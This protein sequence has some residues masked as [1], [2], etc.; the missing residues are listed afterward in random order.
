MHI[1]VDD[2]AISELIIFKH[3]HSAEEQ[4]NNQPIQ[5]VAE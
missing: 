4:K 5:S 2:L 1:F 3:K